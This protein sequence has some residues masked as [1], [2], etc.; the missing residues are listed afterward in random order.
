MGVIGF[1]RVRLKNPSLSSA[2][3]LG[4][5]VAICPP[6]NP[7]EFKALAS[8]TH[9]TAD[10]YERDDKH[11]Y[12]KNSQ[13]FLSKYYAWMFLSDPFPQENLPFSFFFSLLNLLFSTTLYLF[14][15]T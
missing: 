5:E 9:H 8:Q 10:R 3:K 12:K 1:N 15:P 11:G 14:V 6:G 7:S 2:L 13:Y 4:A